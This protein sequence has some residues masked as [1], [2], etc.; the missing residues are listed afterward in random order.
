VAGEY[1]EPRG[2]PD[3]VAVAFYALAGL[4]RGLC[5]RAGGEDTDL[6]AE[7]ALTTPQP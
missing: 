4:P 5:A 2:R 6:D 7:E 3:R 1:Q